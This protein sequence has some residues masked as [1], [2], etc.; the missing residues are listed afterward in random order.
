[1]RF[2]IR[3]IAAAFLLLLLIAATCHRECVAEVRKGVVPWERESMRTRVLESAGERDFDFLVGSW[4]VANRRLKKRHVG[5][6]EWDEFPA[7]VNMRPILKGLG[8]VDEIHFPTKG[9]SGMSLRLF[10][11][12]TGLWSIYW[13]NSRDGLMQPPVVGAFRNG[14]GEFFG[15][16]V[17]EGRPI[18]V[19]Y[20]WLVKNRDLARWEQA[21]SLDSG[22]SWETNWVMDL[23]RIR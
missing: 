4:D 14:V 9:W 15:D 1:M 23:V 16:D 22:K 19:R 8:N 6:A 5:S 3:L 17:D 7:R 21:F 12:E 2:E 11:P 13:V 18:R 20:R 10:N